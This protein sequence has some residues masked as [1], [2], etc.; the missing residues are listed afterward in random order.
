MCLRGYNVMYMT[1]LPIP[2]HG[3][4]LGICHVLRRTPLRP[5][6]A[7]VTFVSFSCVPP[8]LSCGTM[9]R[10]VAHSAVY[11]VAPRCPTPRAHRRY[12]A[13][14][15]RAAQVAFQT[16]VW[17]PQIAPESG[18]PCVDFLKEAWKAT[19]GLRDVLVMLRQLL[20]SPSQGAWAPGDLLK[21]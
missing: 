8:T 19:S 16:R 3:I 13:R 12:P 5:R 9:R 7:C 14:V 1:P 15:L 4:A 18:K 10:V 17:H 20:G 21:R 2:A 11:A 6:A